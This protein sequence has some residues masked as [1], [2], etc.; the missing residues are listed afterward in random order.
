[1]IGYVAL[2]RLVAPQGWLALAPVA[3]APEW[4]GRRLGTRLVW[5][6][7]QVAKIKQQRVV[8]IG[9]PSFYARAGFSQERAAALQLPYPLQYTGLFAPGTDVPAVEVIYT[10]AFDGI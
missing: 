8:V 9:K 3:I 6:T 1:M 4:Q 2:S 7:M 5:M 10:A